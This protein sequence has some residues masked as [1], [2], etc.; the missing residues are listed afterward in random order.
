VATPPPT[1][2]PPIQLPVTTTI[3]PTPPNPI[4]EFSPVSQSLYDILIML[5]VIL[6][7]LFAIGMVFSRL[8][9]RSSKEVSF[10]RTGFGGVGWMVVVTGNWIGG[11]VV[12]GGVATGGGPVSTIGAG[13]FCGISWLA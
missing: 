3:Q 2:D 6:V 7:A 10:V 5:A 4:Q 11:S 9:Q 12:G 8:Y 13:N 1:T